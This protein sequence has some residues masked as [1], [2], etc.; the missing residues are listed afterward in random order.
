MKKKIVG[1]ILLLGVLGIKFYQ[2]I[3]LRKTQKDLKL[4]QDIVLKNEEAMS[5]VLLSL[6]KQYSDLETTFMAKAY[7][8]DEHLAL[9]DEQ[10]DTIYELLQLHTESMETLIDENREEITTLYTHLEELAKADES[11]V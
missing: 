2:S 9:L 4:K 5:E 11:E 6:N 3:K 7:I 10:F 1:G 8:T